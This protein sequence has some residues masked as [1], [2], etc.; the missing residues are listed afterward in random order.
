MIVNGKLVSKENSGKCTLNT[1]LKF[2]E[3]LLLK[4]FLKKWFHKND[5]GFL[6][7]TVL[8]YIGGF[9]GYCWDYV[10]EI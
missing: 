7:L 8:I 6:K 3:N 1:C 9:K 4:V 10:H 2:P 5:A